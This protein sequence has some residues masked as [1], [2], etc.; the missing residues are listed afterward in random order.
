V[1]NKLLGV[2]QIVS[3]L[4]YSTGA[5]FL[6]NKFIK[7]MHGDLAALTV[8]CYHSVDKGQAIHFEQQIDYL[9]SKN[10]IFLAGKE[11]IELI[12]NPQKYD[13]NLLYICLTF[14][15]CYEDN[16]TVV[17]DILLRKEIPA[18][19]FAVS[20]M[21][22]KKAIWDNKMTQ[23][24]IMTECQLAE[25]ANNFDIGAHTQHHR[26]LDELTGEDILMEIQ[27][28]KEE[29][30]SILKREIYLFAYP[31]GSYNDCVLKYVSQLNFKAAFT[32]EQHTNYSYNEKYKLGRYIVN[33]EDM[34]DFKLKVAGG[35]DWAF[36]LKN[37]ISYWF[38][39]CKK[40]TN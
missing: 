32:I 34:A 29:L 31:H 10:Y 16:F 15:D 4:L 37:Q 30:S 12:N 14:D 11:L 26:K 5:I 20:A 25:M 38:S 22:G 24:D 1:I 8:L 33:P 39:F 36:L 40:N 28:S 35:Y 9:T 18:I 21:L 7:K 19:F 23:K 6:I 17:R 27:H 13:R 3:K 2:K